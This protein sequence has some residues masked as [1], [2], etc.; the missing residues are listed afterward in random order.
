MIGRN[1]KNIKKIA[2]K[3]MKNK[4]NKILDL[5]EE[6]IKSL[7]ILCIGDIML[8]HYVYGSV[9]RLSPEAPIP[10][11]SYEKEMFQLGGVGNV[12]KNINDIGAYCTLITITGVD[13]A[14]KKI[15]ELI[16]QKKNIKPK[17][18][19]IKNFKTPIKKR[20][21]KNSTHL[22]RVD[23]ENNAYNLKKNDENKI[24]SILKKNIISSDLI[25]LSDYNK[26]F[27][28]KSLIKE[29]V[30]IARENNRFIITD[31]KKINFSHYKNI[32][33]ITPNQKEISDSAK[34]KLKSE[35][36]IINFSRKIMNKFNINEVLVTRAN[37]G[38]LLI[39]PKY[40]KKI[41]A[42]A[43]KV[44]DVTGAGDTVISILG[45][46]KAMGKN[47]TDASILA[48]SAA[49][50]IIGKHGTESLSLNELISRQ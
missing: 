33:I 25:I 1:I 48:N 19:S 18:I 43:K 2:Q 27:L 26:G 9:K 45:I 50:I 29:I 46:M 44:I 5:N 13:N 14:S 49:G 34:T 39:G 31:P 28:N 12:A 11:L 20:Y 36:E 17:L 38:M 4:F 42:N 24:K 10:I 15:K 7:R 8:D 47:T 30:K 40:V 37:K 23:H 22:L 6:K 32:N 16:S 21:I 3:K 41:K 35:K